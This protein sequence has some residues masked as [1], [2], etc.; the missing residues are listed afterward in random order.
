[1]GKFGVLEAR[2]IKS[3][4]NR[5]NDAANDAVN[6]DISKCKRSW[7]NI[8]VIAVISEFVAAALSFFK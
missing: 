8:N 3:L 6:A 4:I 1:M 2:N 5:L 7:L